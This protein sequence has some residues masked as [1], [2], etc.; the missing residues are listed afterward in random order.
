L[1]FPI[2][3]TLKKEADKCWN[4]EIYGLK[5]NSCRMWKWKWCQVLGA[6]VSLSRSFRK[7]LEDIPAKHS[8][9]EL[10]KAAGMR[11]GHVLECTIV[12][13]HLIWNGVSRKLLPDES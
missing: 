8:N 5:H 3:D 13:L 9:S 10:Q 1:A 7:Y 2:K 6:N 12:T 4:R 11:T